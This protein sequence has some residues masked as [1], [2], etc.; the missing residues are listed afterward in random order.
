MPRCKNAYYAVRVGHS[1]GVYNTWAECQLQV[2]NFPKCRFKKF[3]S[4]E[5]A[6]EF[7]YG[8][9]E[10]TAEKVSND[11]SPLLDTSSKPKP[12]DVKDVK[13]AK[14]VKNVAK[15]SSSS[16]VTE[17]DETSSLED[18]DV[19]KLIVWTDGCSLNNGR[20]GARAGVGVFWSVNDPRNLSEKLPG[21][22]QTNNRAEIMAIIR[23]LETCPSDNVTL[24]IKTD[25]VYVMKAYKSWI[26][27]WEKNG[28]KNKAKKDVENKDLFTRM[29]RL[30]R[31]RP[32][33]VLISHV[34]GHKGI[35]GNEAADR[36]A[37]LGA[38]EDETIDDKYKNNNNFSVAAASLE[39]M[40]FEI[41][42]DDLFSPEELAEIAKE[43][44]R[45][46]ANQTQ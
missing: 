19:T 46:Q 35:A 41:T 31:A 6:Q 14:N 17:I 39:S 15:S 8:N 12:K 29:I 30:I 20:R 33:K 2:N 5:D 42:D 38:L 24:E 27:N 11:S 44:A 23:A 10:P 25:S 7:V 45:N 4:I 3:T 43:I 36:L 40:D 26:P 9:I 16:P 32:G 18:S 22:R 37:N 1:P 28:W 21:P 34:P 13:N